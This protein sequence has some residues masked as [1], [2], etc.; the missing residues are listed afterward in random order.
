M[1]ARGRSGALTPQRLGRGGL[2][3]GRRLLAAAALCAAALPVLAQPQG[4]VEAGRRKAQACIVCHGQ[5]GLAAA[6]DAPN[7]AGQ[8]VTYLF[9][10]LL[11]YRSGTRRHEVMAVIAR[12]LTDTDIADLAAWFNAIRVEVKEP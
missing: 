5:L 8:P 10:Q 6:P 12:P 3:I 7:L 2:A 11:A 4:S 9:T 1:S